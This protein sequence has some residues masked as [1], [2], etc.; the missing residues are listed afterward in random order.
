MMTFIACASY[1]KLL[2][3]LQI[4]ICV[5][6]FRKIKDF[7]YMLVIVLLPHLSSS[8]WCVINF[9][10]NG[11]T[12]YQLW[13]AFTKVPKCLTKKLKVSLQLSNPSFSKGNLISNF[14]NTENRNTL[15]KCTADPLFSIQLVFSNE[16]VNVKRT[17]VSAV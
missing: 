7:K 12:V 13:L 5:Q 10:G 6:T 4:H 11:L 15:S 1:Y 3:D 17:T 14:Y 8:L 9:F 16:C 2:K